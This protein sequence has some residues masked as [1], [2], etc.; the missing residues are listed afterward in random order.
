M[1]LVLLMACGE[2][3]PKTG[4]DCEKSM[5]YV[6]PGDIGR[7]A[8]AKAW[9]LERGVELG[10]ITPWPSYERNGLPGSTYVYTSES[11]LAKYVSPS[12]NGGTMYF[13]DGHCEVILS[14]A[15]GRSIVAHELLHTLGYDDQVWL[16][17]HIL[18]A[19]S[20]LRGPMMW[21]VR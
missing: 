10:P 1:F 21:G 11:V 6:E 16:P 13:E 17:G 7:V 20:E 15:A 9:L 4:R 14:E 19:F 3:M 2:E 8:D 12:A 5:L 18:F